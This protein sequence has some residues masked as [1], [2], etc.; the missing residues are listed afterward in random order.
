[1][2]LVCILFSFLY[3]FILP[4]LALSFSSSK[5]L[6]KSCHVYVYNPVAVTCKARGY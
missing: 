5:H 2:I 3:Y 1:M 4:H 6:R